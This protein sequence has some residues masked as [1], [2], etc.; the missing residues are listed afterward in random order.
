M[1]VIANEPDGTNI[2]R[3]CG[4]MHPEGM[5]EAVR[6]HGAQLGIAHDGDA[7]RVLFC[8][9]TGSLIDGDDVLVI[10]AMDM[11][12]SNQL[13]EKTVVA[14]VMSNAGLEP[15]MKSLEVSEVVSKKEPKH[16]AKRGV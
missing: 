12:S 3:N 5:C 4:S 9:E 8:D 1:I 15:A 13:A 7:D 10:A 2:N 14:T 16:F 11:L 6:V